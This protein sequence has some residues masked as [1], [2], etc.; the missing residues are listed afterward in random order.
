M[1]I[2]IDLSR[3]HYGTNWIYLRITSLHIGFCV[4]M[5]NLIMGFL[6]LVYFVVLIN[7]STLGFFIPTRGIRKGSTFS[8]FIFSNF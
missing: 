5:V 6:S 8:P 2:N 4:Q 3:G 7:G 1:V